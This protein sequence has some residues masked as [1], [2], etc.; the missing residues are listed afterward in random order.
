VF[1][2]AD[3]V[4]FGVVGSEPEHLD[5]AISR[6]RDACSALTSTTRATGDDKVGLR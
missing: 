1:G 4:R 2:D 5:L 3:H 6:I